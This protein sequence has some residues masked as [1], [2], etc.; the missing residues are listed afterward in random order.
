MKRILVRKKFLLHRIINIPHLSCHVIKRLGMTHADVRVMLCAA[1]Q[2][3]F[4]VIVMQS[5]VRVDKRQILSCRLPDAGV[6]RIA[7][8]DMV[9]LYD[10][11]ALI[12][13]YEFS[14]T[15]YSPVVRAVVN[16]DNF[17]FRIGLRF[18]ALQAFIEV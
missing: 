17:E 13:L 11:E 8:I 6:S 4:E 18:D 16:D 1:A 14:G 12:L 15:L 7:G 9:I 5:V 3:N 10:T 2:Q